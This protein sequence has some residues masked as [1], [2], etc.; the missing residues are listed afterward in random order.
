MPNSIGLRLIYVVDED[1]SVRDGLSRLMDSAGFQILPC[2]SVAEFLQRVERVN[3]ACVLLDL[4]AVRKCE[5]SVRAV[6]Q[7]VA[8]L[9]PV[10]ALTDISASVTTRYA[11]EVGARLCFRKPVDSAALFDAIDW[12][13]PNGDQ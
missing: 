2:S 13:L 7:A 5:P 11:R 10:I 3:N 6:L 4:G 12:S 8:G 1:A 9:L